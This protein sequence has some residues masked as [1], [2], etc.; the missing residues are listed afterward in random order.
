MEVASAE[1]TLVIP[2]RA[3]RPVRNLLFGSEI[4]II[5]APKL[6]ALAKTLILLL[7]TH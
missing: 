2:H 1:I 7:T 4:E 3:E 5:L 6:G